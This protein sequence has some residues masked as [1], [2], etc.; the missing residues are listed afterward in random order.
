MKTT[1]GLEVSGLQKA[2]SI[3]TYSFRGHSGRV[4][5]IKGDPY[6][7]DYAKWDES[8]RAFNHEYGDLVFGEGKR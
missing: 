1:K 8:G 5:V 4:R 7:D 6:H 3:Q 2:F